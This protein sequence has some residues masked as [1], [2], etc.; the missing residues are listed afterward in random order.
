M[1]EYHT[2]GGFYFMAFIGAAVYFVQQAHNFWTGVLG[3]IKAMLWPAVLIYQLLS[4][5]KG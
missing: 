1:K 3:I 4:Y 2:S 5:L